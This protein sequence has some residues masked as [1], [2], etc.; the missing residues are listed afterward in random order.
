MN[1]SLHPLEG[2]IEAGWRYV[3]YN[4][5]ERTF[6]DMNA[7]AQNGEG[8]GDFDVLS[9]W[10]VL[11]AHSLSLM[12]LATSQ[13]GIPARQ[14]HVRAQNMLWIYLGID[15]ESFEEMVGVKDSHERHL[16]AL[17]RSRRYLDGL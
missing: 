7:I 14:L 1:P 4:H 6:F 17:D 15:R 5:V 8:E 2:M 9:M 12:H 3:E 10:Q 13:T 16:T 11:I